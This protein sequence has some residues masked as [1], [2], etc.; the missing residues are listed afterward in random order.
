MSQ[1]WLTAK[2]A[3]TAKALQSKKKTRCC[4]IVRCPFLNIADIFSGKPKLFIDKYCQIK[5]IKPKTH[6]WVHDIPPLSW[7]YLAKDLVQHNEPYLECN[8]GVVR[9]TPASGAEELRRVMEYHTTKRMP[10]GC[11][12][13]SPYCGMLLTTKALCKLQGTG[14]VNEVTATLI[15]LPKERYDRLRAW[16]AYTE[17]ETCEM[18]MVPPQDELRDSDEFSSLGNEVLQ[19]VKNEK[20]QDRLWLQLPVQQAPFS[21]P[22]LGTPL[23]RSLEAS[24]SL[25]TSLETNMSTPQSPQLHRN[26]TRS[27]TATP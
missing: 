15:L 11:L 1:I 5:E 10:A 13:M 14:R 27:V 19:R 12:G 8:Q 6:H 2:V 25:R 17:L 21:N 16:V 26:A 3:K 24:T 22:G 23:R 4:S 9:A 7:V 18:K 20:K